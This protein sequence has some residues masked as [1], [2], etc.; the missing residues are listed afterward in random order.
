MSSIHFSIITP[1]FNRCDLLK[2]S[3]TSVLKQTYKDFELIII[4]DGSTDD[5][6]SLIEKEFPQVK[7]I[8]TQ[9]QGVSAARNLG[10]KNSKYDWVCFLDSDDQW[11]ESK[12]EAYAK[13]IAEN[14]NC[15]L[16][17]SNEVWYRNGVRVNQMKKHQKGGGDQFE[18]SLEFC[19][20]SPST[21]CM[22]KDIFLELGGFREDFEVCED[23]DL[24]LKF[25]SLYLVDFIKEPLINKFGGH[26][27]QLSTK[28]FAMDAWR[29]KSL[30]WVLENRDLD[31]K[32]AHKLKTVLLKKCTVLKKGYE[33]HAHFEK[34]QKLDLLISKYS[35]TREPFFSS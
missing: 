11:H 4:D 30:C 15:K 28:F 12:L 6:K 27:D 33:K 14:R 20:I 13:Y 9:N 35:T 31:I 10:V 2:R 21:V 23:Y 3:I 19:T 29:I 16:L 1:S 26:E 34:A 17:H 18:N 22:R 25:T 8:Y 7:Y 5:T 32:R 24:W